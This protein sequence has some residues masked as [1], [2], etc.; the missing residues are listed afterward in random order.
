MKPRAWLRALVASWVLSLAAWAVPDPFVPVWIDASARLSPDVVTNV[1]DRVAAESAA[2]T[3]LVLWVHGLD[4]SPQEG[5]EQY[6]ELSRRLH[7][8]FA[9]W[10]REVQ[11]VGVQW[12]SSTSGFP[13]AVP[14]EYEERTRLARRVG[15][16]GLRQL[17]LGLQSRFPQTR[18][19]VMAHSLG[20]EVYLAAVRPGLEYAEWNDAEREVFEDKSE[21][22][23]HAAVW[24][25]ADLDYDITAQPVDAPSLDQLHLLWMTQSSL[26]RKDQRDSVLDLRAYLRGRAWGSTFPRMSAEQYNTLLQRRA[27]V[28]DGARIPFDHDIMKYYDQDRLDHVTQALLYQADPEHVRPPSEIA[29][30]NRVMDAPASDEALAPFL[31]SLQLSQQIYALWRLERQHGADAKNLASGYLSRV[32]DVLFRTPRLVAGL[33]EGSPSPTVAAGLY[34]TTLQLTRAGLPPW[35]PKAGSEN[36]KSFA[37]EVTAYDGESLSILS[38]RFADPFTF[39]V[40]RETRFTPQ[41]SVLRIGSKVRVEVEG[42]RTRSVTIVPLSVWLKNAPR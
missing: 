13:F 24:A 18:I 40:P 27:A 7:R 12:D 2:P 21:I 10:S 33:R 29:G 41:R 14:G 8:S 42:S 6:S 4:T 35:A 26:F 34:P 36:G 17:L 11:V 30:I 32:A 19:S 15:R 25:G 9:H 20:C 5:L 37:G 39:S 1:A 3:D 23:L 16:Y 38:D 22:R 28:F 31:D